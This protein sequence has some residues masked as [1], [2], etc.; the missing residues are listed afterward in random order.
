M[1]RKQTSSS[2]VSSTEVHSAPCKCC[3]NQLSLVVNFVVGLPVASNGRL[4]Q[5]VWHT[6]CVHQLLRVWGHRGHQAA[7]I[8]RNQATNLR[9]SKTSAKLGQ[10]PVS[11]GTAH[12]WQYSAVVAHAGCTQFDTTC[13]PHK[14]GCQPYTWVSLTRGGMISCAM[15]QGSSRSTDAAANNAT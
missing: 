1:V 6:Q 11:V 2:G 5:A 13:E 9:S 15:Y 14:H 8:L 12:V 3:S 10:H 7:H 4:H